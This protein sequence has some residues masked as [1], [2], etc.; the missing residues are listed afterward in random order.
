MRRKFGIAS[1]NMARELGR[2]AYKIP[3]ASVQGQAIMLAEGLLRNRFEPSAAIFEK[4]LYELQL[5]IQ[6][7]EAH[8]KS[9]DE[10]V[11]IYRYGQKAWRGEI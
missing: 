2:I 11:A 7:L 1:Q 6:A 9:C 4:Y 3:D 5:A 10:L 8:G